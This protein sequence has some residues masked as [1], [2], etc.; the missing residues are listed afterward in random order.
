MHGTK[1]TPAVQGNCKK[2]LILR[3]VFQMADKAVKPVNY[4]AEQT[5]Q[6][7]SDYQSGVSVET[8]AL[9]L[10]KTVRSVIAKLSR[11]KV[12]VSKA[13]TTKNGEKPVKKDAV[14]DAIGAVLLMTEAEITSLTGANKTALAKIFAALANSKPL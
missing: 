13:Y 12:Y 6:M 4:T 1:E 9:A 14:A 7:V 5:A 10:G 11:E 2:S 3:K 8:I